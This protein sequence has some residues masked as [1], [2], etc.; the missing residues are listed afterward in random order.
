MA[1]KRSLSAAMSGTLF[2]T[3]MNPSTTII[4]P[5][6]GSLPFITRELFQPN[7]FASHYAESAH[8][9]FDN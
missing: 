3:G 8:K 5:H 1:T 9:L 4:I 6:R 2:C 7:I